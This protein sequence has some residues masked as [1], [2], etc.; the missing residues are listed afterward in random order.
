M[1]KTLS[2]NISGIIFH[3]E[4]DG[5]ETLRKYLDSINKYFSSFEDSSE[6]LS[7]IESRIAEI[8]LAKLNEGK[9]V[10]T[11]EDV[12]SLVTTMGNVS[13]FK[14]A[15][16]NEF[17]SE[18]T[19]KEEQR[20]TST[21]P[22]NKKL[23]RDNRRKILGGVG[24]GLGHYF[25]VDP[26]WIRLIFVL[27][28]GPYGLGVILYVIL[29]IALP[30]EDNLEE[31]ASVKKMY[32]SSD[33]KVLAGV[34]GGVAAFF[35][36]D[37]AVTRIFFVITSFFG[38]FG[39]ILYLVLWFSLPEAKTITEKMEMQGEPVTLSNIES[40]VKK[41][42]NEKGE[43][44]STLAKIVL[45]PFRAIAAVIK[46][47][48]QI[49][50]PVLRGGVEAFRV[51]I[52][53][54]ILFTGIMMVFSVL[55]GFGLVLGFISFSSLPDSW[56]MAHLETANFPVE[57]MT[58]TFPTWTVWAA[59]F[60]TLIPSLFIQFLGSSIIAKRWVIRPMVGWSM[61]VVFFVSLMIVGVTVP[62]IALSFKEDGE[63]KAEKV[64]NV[65]GKT[66]VFKVN[67]VG[68]DDYHVTD[69][70]IRGY[71]GKEIK[72][73]EKFIAQGRTRKR[74]IENAQ[75]VSYTAQQADSVLTF[76]SN[77]TFNKDATF[78]AQRLEMELLVPYDQKFVMDGDMWRLIDNSGR[79]SYSE[80]DKAQ[81]WS[82]TKKGLEC[83]TCPD[84][85]KR[86]QGLSE[87]DQFGLKD[88]DELDIQGVFNLDI[89]QGDTYSIEMNGSEDEK[90]K[91]RVEL[92]GNTLEI[93]YNSR[94][95]TFWM[96][97]LD[98][99]DPF[100]INITMPDLK[101]LKVKGAGKIKIDGFREDDVD[102][103]LLG[104]MACE[105]NLHVRNLQLDLSGP[106]VFELDGEGDFLE[107]EV[108]KVAQLKASGYEVRHAIVNAREL[109]HARVN[110]SEKVEI[111]TD[112]TGSVKYQGSPEVI[113]K[114]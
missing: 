107:A 21:P 8:F 106:M 36:I 89:R 11:A 19:A 85:P 105:A 7:D 51:I 35:G 55:L 2:I 93:S 22:A 77:I 71:E 72:L 15:E 12:Q 87:T 112:V 14:A 74:A 64:F 32:R 37:L 44:E 76:D 20:A 94:N 65:N 54:L 78:H 17:A 50:G 49:L 18:S 103:S 98:G 9:Q 5:Y 109:G 58:A 104:A 96:K 28:S 24:A 25:G 73:M 101:K 83:A 26:V 114:D 100:R 46:F 80:T 108:N 57:A 27:L 30:V 69:L 47:I 42:L 48:G 82:M 39:V 45:F 53:I 23:V 34:A 90:R 52:G 86:E 92:V 10:I 68:L 16:E 111:E 88:F 6:I 66:A 4:E 113:R 84:L 40:S 62:R 59:F 67:E 3:I 60:V 38:G 41:S 102:I 91:Y 63:Y 43:E 33:K 31:E 56:N 110:A 29:W 99:D 81:T 75:T 13:D 79:W 70:V 95:K 1:K 97:N 61:F